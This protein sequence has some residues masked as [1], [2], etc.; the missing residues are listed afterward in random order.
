MLVTSSYLGSYISTD[1][2]GEHHHQNEHQ[3][4]ELIVHDVGLGHLHHGFTCIGGICMDQSEYDE[5]REKYRHCHGVH[6]VNGIAT[7]KQLYGVAKLI[8]SLCNST[9]HVTIDCRLGNPSFLQVHPESTTVR[10]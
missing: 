8:V 10:T 1:Q 7:V 2:A 4:V 6:Y 5:N 3:N 9:N